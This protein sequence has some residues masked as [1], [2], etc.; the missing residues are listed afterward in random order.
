MKE[1]DPFYTKLAW[2]IMMTGVAI[3]VSVFIYC[4]K[5]GL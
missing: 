1:N 2:A 5:K 4:T 3:G